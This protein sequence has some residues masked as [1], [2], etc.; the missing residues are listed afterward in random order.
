MLWQWLFLGLFLLNLMILWLLNRFAWVRLLGLMFMALIPFATVF[1]DQPRFDL[2]YYWWRVA[3]VIAILLGCGII[4]WA[5][6]TFW[7]AGM[8]PTDLPKKLVTSGPYQYVRHPL[9]LGLVFFIVGWWWVWS[10]VYSFYFGM[11][12]LIMLWIN[13]Y[14]EEKKIMEPQFGDEYKGYKKDTGMFWIK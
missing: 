2:D 8:W 4:G 6:L 9:Y 11:G 7:K 14:W 1:F 12:M 5:K 3:G 10:A 13:A